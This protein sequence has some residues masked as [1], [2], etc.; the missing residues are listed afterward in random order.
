MNHEI[1]PV[2]SLCNQILNEWMENT[3]VEIEIIDG[4]KVDE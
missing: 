4:E 1:V 3:R 2:V